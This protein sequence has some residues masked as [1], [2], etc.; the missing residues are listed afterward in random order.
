LQPDFELALFAPDVPH[1][2]A[3]IALYHG[4]TL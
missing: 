2:G 4:E 1:L 3:G